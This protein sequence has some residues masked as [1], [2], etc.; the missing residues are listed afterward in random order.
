LLLYGITLYNISQDAMAEM[1]VPEKDREVIAKVRYLIDIFP[2]NNFIIR[3]R[4]I[5]T[6]CTRDTQNT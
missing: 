4:P 6:C 1:E 2:F 5:W 3:P